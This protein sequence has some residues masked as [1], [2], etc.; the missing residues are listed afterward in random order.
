MSEK[1]SPGRPVTRKHS[2]DGD[3]L[4]CTSC[5]G[6]FPLASFRTQ[7]ASPTG[8]FYRCKTCDNRHRSDLKKAKR[9]ADAARQAGEYVPV[10]AGIRAK[11]ARRKATKVCAMCAKAHPIEDYEELYTALD[12]KHPFCSACQREVGA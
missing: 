9:R 11:I 7:R 12:G 1:K 5:G 4:E 3:Q 8:K 6:M 2:A 10:S